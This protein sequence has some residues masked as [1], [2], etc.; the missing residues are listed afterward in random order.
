[1]E[2]NQEEKYTFFDIISNMLYYDEEYNEQEESFS[3]LSCFRY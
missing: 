1:M 2:N 3:F